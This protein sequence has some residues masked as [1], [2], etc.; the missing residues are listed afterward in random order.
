PDFRRR[1]ATLEELHRRLVDTLDEIPRVGVGIGTPWHTSVTAVCHAL[2][3]INGAQGDTRMGQPL[4]RRTRVSAKNSLSS[5]TR[6]AAPHTNHLSCP[7][8]RPPIPKG[9]T[10]RKRS[11]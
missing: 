5:N 4:S 11:E 8:R 3:C 6:R 10:R 9:T 7:H 1:G 2:D